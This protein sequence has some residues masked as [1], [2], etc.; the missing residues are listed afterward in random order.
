MHTLKGSA[1]LFGFRLVSQ[2]A[3]A[4]EAALEPI[5]RFKLQIPIPL[6]D[7]LFKAIDLVERIVKASRSK[8][9]EVVERF[10]DEA[11]LVIPHL[12]EAISAHFSTELSPSNE[13]IV[14]L[15]EDHAMSR[16][17]ESIE[18]GP[19]STPEAPLSHDKVEVQTVSSESQN[20]LFTSKEPG[21]LKECTEAASASPDLNGDPDANSSVRI[22]VALLDRLMNLVG[23]M[24][25]VRNQMIQ[26]GE[27]HDAL[28]FLTLSQRLDVVTS[29]LQGEVMKT[30]M[31]PVGSILTQFQRLVRDLGKDLGKQIDLVLQGADTELDKT[32]LEAIKDPL[33]HIIR[34]SC[35]H[36]IETMEERTKAGKP[37]IG[38]IH[39]RALHEGGHVIIE[40]ND[41]GR[42]L[43]PKKILSKA[44]E[45]RV[46]T[47]E[48]ARSLTER[49]IS[50]L[51]FSPLFYCRE[52]HFRIR[53]RGRNGRGPNKSRTDW[54]T[55]RTAK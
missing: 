16:S 10:N 43:S 28:E 37:A 50:N 19:S 30:R 48:V 11:K 54:R 8:K 34:N 41:D 29:E 6:A 46:I 49:E 51:I 20:E 23:E 47:Q 44:L 40:I 17:L 33:T 14:L 39:L 26:Y 32:L 36:G 7:A 5:R 15:H 24:V 9:T 31:Q 12:I 42:G 53:A 13:R 27:K 21:A 2:I 52:G 22:N 45:R 55:S 38:H 18:S 1:Q 4:M 25:L 3:H 35:D